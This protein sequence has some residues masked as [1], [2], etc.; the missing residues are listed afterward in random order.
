MDRIALIQ[1]I[2]QKAGFTT[3]LEIGTQSGKSFL[4]VRCANKM[5]VDPDFKIP[6]EKKLKWIIK[7]PSNIRSRY[8]EETSDDFFSRRKPILEKGID[9]VLI[10]GLH[11]FEASLKD[12][13][14]SLKYLNRKGVIILHDCYPPDGLSATPANSKEDLI[15]KG[16][17]GT[18]ELWCGDVW[19]TIYYLRRFFSDFLEVYV[20][21]TDF[22]LGIVRMKE[23]IR[24]PGVIDKK[25][26]EEI[27]ELTFEEMIRDPEEFLGIKNEDHTEILIGEIQG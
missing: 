21:D 8:F 7:N 1:N 4:P 19:K 27:N 5:A 3:Y 16:L 9:V 12:V 24:E 25:K 14:N 17:M 10:D 15:K 18:E 6:F 26:F 2:L 23:E 13:L 11:T 22:G 20:I